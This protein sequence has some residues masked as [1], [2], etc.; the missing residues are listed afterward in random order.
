MVVTKHGPH[1]TPI[2]YIYRERE[3]F[4]YIVDYFILKHLE[5]LTQII[6]F[7]TFPMMTP[8]VDTCELVTLIEDIRKNV[9]TTILECV[10]DRLKPFMC[11]FMTM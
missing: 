7:I 8:V 3:S 5:V 11:Y 10:T 4:K 9:T 6:I 1:V 2:H